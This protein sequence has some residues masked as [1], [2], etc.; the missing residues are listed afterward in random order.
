MCKDLDPTETS[1]A[2]RA[3]PSGPNDPAASAL[4]AIPDFEMLRKLGQGAAG[5]VWLARR[6]ATGRCYAIKT[7]PRNGSWAEAESNGVKWLDV[8][9][10]RSANLIEIHHVG[11]TPE[12]FYYVMDLADRYPTA[13]TFSPEHYK[14]RTLKSDLELRGPLPLAEAVAVAR[15][16]LAGVAHLH[17]HDL[18][19]RDVKPANIVFVDRVAKL[20]DIGLLSEARS[21]QS[22]AGTP[23]YA[24]PGGAKDRSGDL[25]CLGRVLYEMVTGLPPARYPEYPIDADEAREA[26][27]QRVRPIIDRACAP[28]ARDR[29]QTAQEFAA[30]LDKVTGRVRRRVLWG[31]GLA[32]VVIIAL[33]IGSLFFHQPARPVQPVQPSGRLDIL[34]KESREALQ[35][36]K[37][38]ANGLPLRAGQLVRAHV[39][40]NPP[41]YPVI[42]VITEAHG[43]QIAYPP[44]DNLA[45]QSPVQELLVPAGIDWWRLSP[46]DGTLLF[47]MLAAGHPISAA[48]LEVTRNGLAKLRGFP[49]VRPDEIVRL[50]N[51]QPVPFRSRTRTIDVSE[52]VESE[53]GM[54]A[55]LTETFA[56]TFDVICGIAVPQV[57]PSET[58]RDE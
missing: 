49:A 56:D 53:P 10:G 23:G 20:A 34:Y 13:E 9:A 12:H 51:G 18:L 21:V 54:L 33:S 37:L 11:Q 39:T 29:F 7:L 41:G 36:Y 24:P 2:K 19:H 8:Y 28:E 25:Y 48:E 35:H 15:Q 38:T 50:V 3:Q 14:P 27:I 4:P 26:A 32:A 43:A 40:L 42:A 44:A 1:S 45:A 46:P 22:G 55:Q 31:A 16:V 6:K 58:D 52:T 5:A 17:Q 57:T 30:A 47:V